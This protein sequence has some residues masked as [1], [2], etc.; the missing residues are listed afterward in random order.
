MRWPF[1]SLK[2]LDAAQAAVDKEYER[3]LRDGQLI[4]HQYSVD[5]TMN[6]WNCPEALLVPRMRAMLQDLN[7]KFNPEKRMF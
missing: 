2:R 7:G 1:V 5:A 3:A 4:V 6:L